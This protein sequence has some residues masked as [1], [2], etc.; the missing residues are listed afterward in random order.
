M[1]GCQL[2]A[3]VMEAEAA[4]VA[5]A[6]ATVLGGYQEARAKAEQNLATPQLELARSLIWE[7]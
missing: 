1:V 5:E 6:S 7:W 4:E 3:R 2:A